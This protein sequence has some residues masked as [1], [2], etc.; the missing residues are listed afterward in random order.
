MSRTAIDR[1]IRFAAK[2]SQCIVPFCILAILFILGITTAEVVWRTFVGRSVPDSISLATVMMPVTAFTAIAM[3]QLAKQHITVTI[4]T[5]RM[6]ERWQYRLALL[7]LALGFCLCCL[8][9]WEGML[10]LIHSFKIQEYYS[11]SFMRLPA[12]PAKLFVPVGLGAVAMQLLADIFEKVL[13]N[14]DAKEEQG[15]WNPSQSA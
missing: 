15:K 3:T 11:G 4:L 14:R 9:T 10:Q 2:V 7:G 6:S 12:W 1:Y 8:A 5:E 13:A